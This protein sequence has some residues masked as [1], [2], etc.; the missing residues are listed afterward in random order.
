MT[1]KLKTLKN[2]QVIDG[3]INCH[4]PIYSIEE[5]YFNLIFPNGQDIEF[6]EDFSK[7]IKKTEKKEERK[8]WDKVFEEMWK[9]RVDKKLVNGIHG[10]LF[11]DADWHRTMYLK[12]KFYP[13]KKEVNIIIHSYNP[14]DKKSKKKSNV[15]Y[16]NYKM[17]SISPIDKN[18]D[19]EFLGVHQNVYPKK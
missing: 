9:N 5:E 4:Y 16:Y 11:Y 2:I 14:S 18:K 7:R 13:D 6:I 8:R 17:S 3:A 10:T 1:Q 19:P 12:K 15:A